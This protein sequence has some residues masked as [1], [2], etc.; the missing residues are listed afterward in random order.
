VLKILTEVK[1][2][3]KILIRITKNYNSR[4]LNEAIINIIVGEINNSAGGLN[5]FSKQ[6]K[7]D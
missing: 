7:M 1:L 3:F 4:F 5:R 6:L 2:V